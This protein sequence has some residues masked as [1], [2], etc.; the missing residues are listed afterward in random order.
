MSIYQS[1]WFK[2]ARVN[3]VFYAL[4]LLLSSLFI[5]NRFFHSFS[6]VGKNGWEPFL[7]I[8]NT[9]SLSPR[10]VFNLIFAYLFNSEIVRGCVSKIKS[11]HWGCWIHC[12]RFSQFNASGFFHLHQIPHYQFLCVVWLGWITRCWSNT[13]I[14]YVQNVLNIQVLFLRVAPIITTYL[15]VKF[16]SECFSKSIWKSFEHDDGVLIILLLE[17]FDDF[18]LF[19]SCADC[20][21]SYVISDST[22]LGCNEISH[23]H[24]TVLLAVKLLSQGV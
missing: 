15:N 10:I 6:V 12:Q 5:I 7:D 24:E 14:F 20:E 13:L 21:H 22:L 23:R 16:F 19:E 17:L 9:S 3:S 18:I 2:S 8:L 1:I 4:Q 11:T